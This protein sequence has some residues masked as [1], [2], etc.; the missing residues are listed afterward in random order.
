MIG[1]PPGLMYNTA[2]LEYIETGYCLICTFVLFTAFPEPTDDNI[3]H[4]N[5]FNIHEESDSDSNISYFSD[6][7][8]LSDYT[9]EEQGNEPDAIEDFDPDKPLPPVPQKTAHQVNSVWHQSYFV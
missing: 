5:P 3:A 6:S 9:D 2:N 7:S 1:W 4:V 8:F